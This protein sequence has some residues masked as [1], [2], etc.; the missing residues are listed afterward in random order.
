MAAVAHQQ[1]SAGAQRVVQVKAARCAAAAPPLAVL[2]RDDHR[3]PAVTLGQAAGHNTDD[4][5]MPVF[6]RHH[7]DPIPGQRRVRL[8]LGHR[9]GKEALLGL[10]APGI[11]FRQAGGDAGGLFLIFTEQQFEG[12]SGGVHAAR[13]VDAGSKA[14][15]DGLRR[16][17]LARVAARLQKRLQAGAHGILQNGKTL[18]HQRAVFPGQRHHIRDGAQRRQIAIHI[19]QL[20]RVG[21][22]QR[23]GQLEGHSR[24]A[25]I[26]EGAFIIGTLGVHHRHRLGQR[27][28]GKMV[29]GDDQIDA[30][31]LGISGLLH[32]GDAVVHRHHQRIAFG[33]QLLQHFPI[34]AIAA[35]IPAGQHAFDLRPQIAQRLEQNRGG[36]DAVHI[37]IAKNDDGLFFFDGRLQAGHRLVHV[38]HQEGVRE[39]RTLP[40]QRLC[41]RRAGTAAPRQHTGQ[42]RAAAAVGERPLRRSRL[43]PELPCSQIH[44]QFLTSFQNRW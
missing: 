41:L 23:G 20:R 27:V 24:T 32:G 4:P 42:Q 17:R 22:L 38:L 19:Q 44:R 2:Q 11:D 33:G 13:R 18:P 31:L 5:G 35:A 36:A 30:Q 34:D 37:I 7:N 25:Q 15:A 9:L 12:H 39:R 28:G 6:P 16:H 21:A 29:V 43:R 26:L 8:Q 14:V 10:L 40:Q 1:V 3:G